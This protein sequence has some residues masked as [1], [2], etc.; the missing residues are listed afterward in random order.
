[1]AKRSEIP[2]EKRWAVEDLYPGDAAWE[3]DYQRV[4]GLIGKVEKYKGHLGDSAGMLKEYLDYADDLDK[5][6]EKIYL[7]AHLNMDVDTTD[8]TYQ[9]MR[10]KAQMLAVRAEE[11]NAFAQPEIMA[12]PEETLAKYRAS[13]PGLKAYDRYFTVLLRR[14]EHTRSR[15]V[16]ELLASASEMASAPSDTFMMLNN[17]DLTFPK[18]VGED[19][20][21][22]EV[23]HGR[24]VGL[25]ESRDRNVRKAA[26]ESMYS[27][28]G[29]F[30][31]TIAA[32]FSAN[33]KQAVFF[34][35]ARGYSSTR[36]MYL[37]PGNI[38][39]EV[40][41]NLIQVVHE[42]LPAMYRYVALRKKLLGVE[43]LHMYD[44]YAPIIPECTMKV[45]FEEARETIL[46][47]LKPMGEEYLS[48]LR[49]GFENRWIDACENA[50]KRSGAYCSGVTVGHPYVLMTY[51]DT[52]DSMF[53]LAHELGHAMHSYFSTKTQPHQ[54]ASYLI[55][56]AEVASTCNEILLTRYLLSHTGD[57]VQKA[58]IINH[59]LD[60]FKGTLFR[61][62]MF[63]EF[64]M[65]AHRKA[66]A[67]E[68]LTA[69]ELNRIYYDLNVKY[70]G[71]DMTVDQE[72]RL[73]WARIPHFY[74]PFYVYQYATGISAAA[75]LSERILTLG[76]EGVKDYM[77]FLTGGGSADPIDLLKMAGV[78]MSKKEPVEAATKLFEDMLGQL[79][80]LVG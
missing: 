76:E 61:Q 46:E 6:I 65:M 75:A 21:E 20:E 32:N 8:V 17:A 9:T 45:T 22:M 4:A 19:G 34:A 29:Q 40:Y 27:S 18:I 71:P 10:M 48:A 37:A 28:Y 50:G 55:F 25:M 67:G 62:T 72:I 74:T 49:E 53:T 16:E 12:I 14:R 43:E 5:E 66:E 57:E 11:E 35:K 13:E 44:V 68:A 64:E 80:E 79:T 51:K 1:M 42:A 31:N 70:F 54:T 58:Y 15:E 23:T 69:G 52:L 60:S 24:Y 3:E 47:A 2:Q 77:K 59:F 39:E 56:V 41:D 38:P 73:E 78:D 26:F 30:A 33:I 7:Y 36:A 63:A